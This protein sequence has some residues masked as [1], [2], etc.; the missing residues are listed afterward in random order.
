MNSGRDDVGAATMPPVGAYVSALSVIRDRCTISLHS[1]SYPDFFVQSCHH[2]IV[3]ESARVG[4]AAC[5][6]LSCD[7]NQASVNGTRSP[8]RTVKSATVEWPTPRVSTG[9]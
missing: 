2:D 9:V 6:T 8:R 4:L 1:P 7:G 3:R 5:G